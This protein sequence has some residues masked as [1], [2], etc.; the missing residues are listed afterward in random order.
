MGNNKDYNIYD[1]VQTGF[2]ISRSL[3]EE[4]AAIAI[5]KDRS[6]SSLLCQI[7]RDYVAINKHPDKLKIYNQILSDIEIDDVNK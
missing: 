2:K 1:K 7:I 5:K 4:F 6:I 3:K